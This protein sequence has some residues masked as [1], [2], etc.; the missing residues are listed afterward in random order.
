LVKF[1]IGYCVGVFGGKI[2]ISVVCNVSLATA[3][4]FLGIK[5]QLY[6]QKIMSG[7]AKLKF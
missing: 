5:L 4:F 3:S 1:H 2:Q 6:E 7:Y